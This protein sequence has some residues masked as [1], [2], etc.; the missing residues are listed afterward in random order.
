MLYCGLNDYP[1]ESNPA[2]I[3]NDR[4]PF[5]NLW[6]YVCVKCSVA[7]VA[8]QCIYNPVY[9][10]MCM[11][12]H[13]DRLL[14]FASFDARPLDCIVTALFIT[15]EGDGD[16]QYT[17]AYHRAHILWFCPIFWLFLYIIMDLCIVG[18]HIEVDDDGTE[19]RCTGRGLPDVEDKDYWDEHV[20]TRLLTV[21]N[22]C[23]HLFTMLLFLYS[24]MPPPR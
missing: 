9:I 19:H 1:Y 21:F 20:S 15:K 3:V 8:P 24:V 10:Y 13:A 23:F 11:Y 14:F 16:R 17:A 2:C 6:L 5:I 12:R 4:Y 18:T 7:V 22:Y